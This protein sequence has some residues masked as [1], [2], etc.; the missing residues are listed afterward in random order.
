MIF[1]GHSYSILLVSSSSKFNDALKPLLLENNFSPITVA[2]SISSAKRIYLE[3]TFDFVIINSPLPDEFGTKFAIDSCT[4]KNTVCLLFVKSDLLD[5]IHF[6]VSKHGVFTLAKP[7]STT[8]ISHALKWMTASSE[9]L[10]K[11]EKK[12]VSVEDKMEEIRIINRAKWI[13]IDKKGMSESDAHHYI[14][15]QS[16]DLCISKK[17][18][19]EKILN[20]ES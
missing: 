10:R 6:K 15:K 17:E 16:M 4:N 3:N 18:I 7:A 13:L 19:A 14:E 9:R 5:E 8:M 11:L 12:N 2:D 20:E 1:D